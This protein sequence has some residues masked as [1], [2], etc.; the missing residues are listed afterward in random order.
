[1][2]KHL[3]SLKLVIIKVLIKTMN[4]VILLKFI[5]NQGLEILNQWLISNLQEIYSSN[6]HIQNPLITEESEL[7]NNDSSVS[8]APPTISDEKRDF[9]VALLNVLRK[10]PI[11]V[12]TLREI[13]IGKNV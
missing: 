13:K 6:P 9:L 1:M 2:P 12:E 11:S 3:E 4:E 5:E 7:D 8:N 10:L